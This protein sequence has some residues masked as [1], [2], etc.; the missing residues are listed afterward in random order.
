MADGL[1]AGL[2]AARVVPVMRT[3]DRRHAATAAQ[4]LRAAGLRIF[5]ITMT[6]PDATTLIRDLA[7]DHALLVGAGTV[8]DR[9]AAEACLAAGTRF[10]RRPGPIPRW[11]GPAAMPGRR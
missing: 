3:R 11:P 4:W 5:E 7:S 1:I 9:S 2:R 10:I 6:V 8:P